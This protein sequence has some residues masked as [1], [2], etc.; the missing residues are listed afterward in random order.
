MDWGC[1][2]HPDR[3]RLGTGFVVGFGCAGAPAL[4]AAL[5]QAHQAGVPVADD[6]EDQE[7][8]GEVVV[9]REGVENGKEKVKAEEDLDPGG[10]DQALAVLGGLG[11]F[12][13]GGDAI[14]GGAD[15]R[16]LDA[17]E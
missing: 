14:F 10:E 1:I 16:A 9:I 7:R 13:L 12:A 17:E 3:E 11:F 6:E 5:Q 8:G 4:E 15:K 2:S